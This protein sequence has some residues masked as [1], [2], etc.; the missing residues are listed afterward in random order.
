MLGVRPIDVSFHIKVSHYYNTSTF[1]HKMYQD[2][3]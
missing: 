3:M 1:V 2:A